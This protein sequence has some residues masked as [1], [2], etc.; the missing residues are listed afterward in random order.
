MSDPA[1]ASSSIRWYTASI[2]ASNA[3]VATLAYVTTLYI[4]DLPVQTIYVLP[5]NGG[6]LVGPENATLPL[7]VATT[8]QNNFVISALNSEIRFRETTVASVLTSTTTILPGQTQ[9]PI[10]TPTTSTPVPGISSTTTIQSSSDQVMVDT[11][12]E[13]PSSITST[14]STTTPN[15]PVPGRSGISVG[16]VVGVAIGAFAAG[17]LLLGII[18]WLGCGRRYRRIVKDSEAN[19]LDPDSYEKG[20]AVGIVTPGVKNVR[21]FHLDGMLSQPLEDKALSGE[22]SKISNLIKNH[23][24]SYYHSSLTFTTIIDLDDI[25]DL[26]SNMPLAAE[27]LCKLLESPKTRE[28]ALRFCIAWVIFS[29]V[30]SHGSASFLPEEVARCLHRIVESNNQNRRKPFQM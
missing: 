19:V 20:P 1:V 24:Q 27:K 5:A 21:S 2:A 17:I 29:R 30:Q 4:S 3:Q 25:E 12:K 8:L 28:I 11:S 6:L 15:I 10:P 13:V 22:V 16:A 14:T 23:V 18:F 9:N 26:G 7:G